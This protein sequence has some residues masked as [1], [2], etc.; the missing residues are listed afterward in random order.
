MVMCSRMR[1][2]A[3]RIVVA[4]LVLIASAA[5]VAFIVHSERQIAASTSALRA[6]DR[7]AREAGDALA[8][9][10]AAEQAYVAA[11]QGAAFWMPKVSATADA[12]TGAVTDMRRAASSAVAREA[13]DQAA[14]RL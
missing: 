10:R 5:A 1:S 12:V 9:A 4:V 8:D 14:A 11:G 6:F 13:L 2:T 7:Q 3:L